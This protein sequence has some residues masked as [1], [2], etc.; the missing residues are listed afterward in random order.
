MNSNLLIDII[1]FKPV[2]TE[3]KTRPGVFL[4][5]GPIQ[6]A[7]A[8]NE[9]G[10]V[11]PKS[12][13]EREIN[14]YNEEFVVNKNAFGELDHPEKPVVDLKNVSHVMTELW[15][16]GNTV[17][18]TLE[19]LPTPSG[20]I[21]RAIMEAGYT[22]G[23]SSRGTGSVK[24]TSEN[25]LQVQSDFG[26]ICWDLVSRPSTFGSFIQPVSSLNEHTFKA[27][28]NLDEVHELIREILCS[29]DSCYCP[30]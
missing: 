17:M 4:A 2:L 28:Q 25:L 1:P 10:R 5:T 23:I 7:E 26:L 11:Y 24:N 8:K 21:A 20:N 13:L 12:I 19:I 16:D 29:V 22:I 27:N 9:N 6:R 15:W 14:K 30:V 3:S 18:G